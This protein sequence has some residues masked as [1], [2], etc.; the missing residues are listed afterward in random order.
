MLQFDEFFTNHKNSPCF[1]DPFSSSSDEDS[2]LFRAALFRRLLVCL[3]GESLVE[4]SSNSSF[5]LDSLSGEFCTSFTSS[6]TILLSASVLSLLELLL[7]SVDEADEVALRL[8][9]D[10]QQDNFSFSLRTLI[11][12]E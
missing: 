6:F 4:S 12:V 10:L 2:I 7:V 1:G 11:F 5:R 8:K 3:I 9:K